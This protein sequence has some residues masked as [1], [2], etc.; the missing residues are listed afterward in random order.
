MSPRS[1]A[2]QELYPFFGVLFPKK[3]WS[4][5]PFQTPYV[6][7][8]QPAKIIESSTSIL[9]NVESSIPPNENVEFPIQPNENDE[10][11]IPHFQSSTPVIQKV[12]PSKACIQNVQPSTFPINITTTGGESVR[13]V[14]KIQ[15]KCLVCKQ[16][17]KGHVGPYGKNKCKNEPFNATFLESNSPPL[18]REPYVTPPGTPDSNED[19]YITPRPQESPGQV[20]VTPPPI[21][22][23]NENPVVDL[24]GDDSLPFFLPS[25]ST[26]HRDFA[27]IENALELDE[28]Q[29]DA[30]ESILNPRE[31]QQT[32]E[33][34]VNVGGNSHF[35]VNTTKRKVDPKDKRPAKKSRG[36]SYFGSLMKNVFSR[37][38]LIE[39]L[40]LGPRKESQP[41]QTSSHDQ[42]SSP[43]LGSSDPQPSRRSSVVCD[44]QETTLDSEYQ[45]HGT[46]LAREHQEEGTSLSNVPNERE[47]ALANDCSSS[48]I[49]F[50]VEPL[51]TITADQIE[52]SPHA[53]TK[54]NPVKSRKPRKKC[55]DES[56]IS[57]NIEQ[58]CQS[59]E[60]CLNPG[61][62][63][64]C[65]LRCDY[66]F[67][68]MFKSP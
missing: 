68:R 36:T 10:S 55:S 46:A 28:T 15:R 43:G 33:T 17:V 56:C 27:E 38:D 16:P 49:T 1:F 30:T 6:P 35:Q 13:A 7:P 53:P 23:E 20:C 41:P 32:N 19:D 29:N 18:T 21:Y 60:S 3:P 31:T 11:F 22:D 57:C 8:V 40:V 58:N 26:I 42:S 39:P 67:N 54:Q 50:A 2:P 66:C 12:Q 51:G 48:N 59:C 5:T 62:K 14:S 63:T 44:E 25:V 4:S 24:C 61:L 47:T 52:C 65:V 9:K 45:E 34:E 64:K 37:S